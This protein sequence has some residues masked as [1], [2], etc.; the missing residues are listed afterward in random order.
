[1]VSNLSGVTSVSAGTHSVAAKSDGTVWSFGANINGQLGNGTNT[2]SN[3]PTLVVNLRLGDQV[4]TPTFS[5]EGG[6]YIQ[7]QSMTVS[8]ATAGAT[9]RYTTDGRE[10]TASDQVIASG[11]SLNVAN[12]T[13]LRAKAFKTGSSPSNTKSG[14]YQIGGYVVSGVNH[15]LAIKP[16]GTLWSWGYNNYGQLGNGGTGEQWSPGQVI[17][18]SN[19]VAAAGGTSHSLA[20]KAD[21]TV[22]AWGKNSNGQLGD[23]TT[24][25]RLT[26]GQVSGLTNVVRIAAGELHSVALKSDGTVWAWGHNGYGSLEMGRRLNG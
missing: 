24:T 25:Q 19:V 16:D 8:C 7:A 18:I 3:V 9:I 12:T 22:W 4:A 21:G 15:S 11:S 23:G 6:F 17:G 1:L 10:P 2:N 14:V 20:T 5:P 26:P 13:F